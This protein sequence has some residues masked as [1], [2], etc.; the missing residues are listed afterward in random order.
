MDM[1]LG[2]LVILRGLQLLI[3]DVTVSNLFPETGH[4]D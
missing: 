4:P 3:R 2:L 1:K